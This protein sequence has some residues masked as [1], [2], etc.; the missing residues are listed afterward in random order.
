MPVLLI[1]AILLAFPFIELYVLIRLASEYGWWIALYLLAAASAGWM[2]IQEE[3]LAVFGRLLQI[4]QTGQHP[5]VALLSSARTLLAGVLL[6]FP[7]VISD[8]FAVLLLLIPMPSSRTPPL[9][10]NRT[11][12]NDDIIEG[13]WKRED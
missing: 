4:V 6:I 9:S 2:L 8:I 13:E 12:A 10:S 11:A 5:V 3:K 1:F 7:G